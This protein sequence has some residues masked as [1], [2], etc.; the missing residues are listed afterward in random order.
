MIKGGNESATV[1]IGHEFFVERFRE[2]TLI[3][4]IDVLAN[5]LFEAHRHVRNLGSVSSDVGEQEPYDTPFTAGRQIVQIAP[6]AAI[7]SF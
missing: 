7:E 5:Q 6:T 1:I 4:R 2:T 3:E